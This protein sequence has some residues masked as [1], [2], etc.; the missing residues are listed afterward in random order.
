MKYYSWIGIMAPTMESLPQCFEAILII[1]LLLELS[2]SLSRTE[3][4]HVLGQIS[5][6]CWRTHRIVL[7]RDIRRHHP[8]KINKDPWEDW[9][10]R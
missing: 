9:I 5:E 2:L 7:C 6:S 4:L 1:I 3:Q 8:N 10:L